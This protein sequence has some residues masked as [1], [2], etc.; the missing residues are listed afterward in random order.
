MNEQYFSEN[1]LKICLRRYG[2]PSM[3]LTKKLKLT[4]LEVKLKDLPHQ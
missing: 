4:V 3:A 1:R 2:I